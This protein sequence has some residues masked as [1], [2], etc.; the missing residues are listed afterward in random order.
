MNAIVI[1]HHAVVDIELR[2]IIGNQ[3]K[4]VRP[5]FFDPKPAGIVDS[6]PLG[7]LSNFREAF[8]EGTGRNIQRI[9]I[10]AATRFQLVESRKPGGMLGNVIHLAAQ[11]RW[12]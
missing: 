7:P 12:T 2:S 9:Y 6:K 11:A 3:A 5:W 1:D 8:S 4:A 10:N